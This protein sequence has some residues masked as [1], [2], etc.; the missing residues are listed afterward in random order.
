MTGALFAQTPTTSLTLAE[1][2]EMARQNNG[3]VRSAFFN[4]E[5]AKA[6]ARGA[7]AAYLPTLSGSIGQ[8]ETQLDTFTGRFKGGERSTFR[9]ASLDLNWK[10]FESGSRDILYQQ[11]LL[12]RDAVEFNTLQTLRS[13]LF[14]VHQ[15][16][17]ESL[18]AQEL[19]RVQDQSLA[20]AQKIYDQTEFRSRPEIGD[21]PRKDL[22]Q[23]EADLLNARVSLLTAQNRR[24]TANAN[25]KA[26]L[27]LSFT[28]KAEASAPQEA[29]LPELNFS[30][31]EAV[32]RGMENRADLRAERI[33]VR[34]QELSVSAAKHDAGLQWSVDARYQRSFAED[35]FG[36][37]SIGLNASYPL[38]DGRRSRENIKVE[39]FSL[40]AQQAS[41]TQSERDATAEIEAAYDEYSQNVVRLQAAKS[42]VEAAREN[43]NAAQESFNKGAS[44][45][46][47]VITAQ[48]TLATAESN[49]V[50]AVYDSYI[51]DVR[52][53]LAM[54]DPMPGEVV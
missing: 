9:D 49:Y 50:E 14:N 19:V 37:A 24:Q 13:T 38:Y 5:A 53:R 52:L 29:P 32:S 8:T 16:F 35:P 30:L 4:Y 25:L 41:L 47:E 17:Y 36:R 42:A 6:N 10:I 43:Y 33:R 48:V 1:A 54:G 44:D 12:N 20:R 3:V 51:S 26:V 39:Q 46:I 18:R 40:E 7:Y 22:K 23:A 28:S 45:L 21:L 34:N 15:A 11:A 31:E 2:L 27:G